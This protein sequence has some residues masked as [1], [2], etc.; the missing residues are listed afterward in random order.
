MKFGVRLNNDELYVG[1]EVGYALRPFKYIL[2]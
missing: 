1:L 2:D